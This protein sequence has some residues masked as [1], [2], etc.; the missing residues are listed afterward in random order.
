MR[1]VRAEHIRRG[2]QH[3]FGQYADELLAFIG[4]EPH[5]A[6]LCVRQ[7]LGLVGQRCADRCQ[8]ATRYG[9]EDWCETKREAIRVGCG[10]PCGVREVLQDLGNVAMLACHRI[11]QSGLQCFGCQK[12]RLLETLAGA[13]VAD[14]QIRDDAFGVHKPFSDT[15]LHGERGRRHVATRP[16]NALDTGNA[17]ALTLV[18]AIG[19]LADDELGHAIRPVLVEITTVEGIP[20]ALF[21]KAVIS[22]EVDDNAV[23][24]ELRSERT[25]CPMRKGE[26]DDI[27]PIEI[28]RRGILHRKASKLR[29]MRRERGKALPRGGMPRHA[30]HFK[31]RVL[32]KDA[33][34]LSTCVPCSAS[35]CY[36]ELSHSRSFHS[37]WLRHRAC[38]SSATASHK[39]YV[40]ICI[41]MHTICVNSKSRHAIVPH[42]R[43][44]DGGS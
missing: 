7:I 26:D 25:R 2:R 41:I 14:D 9:C 39:E 42:T 15:R 28:L 37:I 32:R 23:R 13:G 40:N 8:D 35:H 44:Y 43:T 31:I 36:R 17:L 34:G 16:R 19:V 5:V 33:Q 22:P 18:G 38:R 11:R 12:I 3:A 30:C 20:R 6:D 4:V 1:G 10:K 24:V 27:V 21:L 29:D